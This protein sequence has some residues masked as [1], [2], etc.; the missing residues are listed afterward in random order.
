MKVIPVVVRA[1]GSQWGYSPQEVELYVEKGGIM[2]EL[3]GMAGILGR[4]FGEDIGV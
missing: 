4:I 1:L 3:L 2:V